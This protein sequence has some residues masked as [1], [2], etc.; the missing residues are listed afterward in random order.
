MTTL[1]YLILKNIAA[2]IIGSAVGKWFSN[3]AMG[4]WFNSKVS[5]LMAWA[6]GRYK[7]EQQKEVELF[8]EK[9][10]EIA[11]RLKNL[12]DKLK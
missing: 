3:T 1:Y 8:Y 4:V 2:S 10:P 11:E 6:T 5:Q 12:E 9:Y 7:V